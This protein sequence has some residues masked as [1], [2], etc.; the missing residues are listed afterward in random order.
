MTTEPLTDAEVFT[1]AARLIETYGWVQGGNGS[2]GR[3]FCAAGALLA[4]LGMSTDMGYL[5]YPEEA[6]RWSRLAG[7]A[8]NKLAK[9][10]GTFA[11]M[12][13]ITSWNDRLYRKKAEVI[14]FLRELAAE[15]T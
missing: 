5:D 4:A 3:G 10:P 12:G 14:T 9:T 11:S 13:G 6:A 15:A 8:D 2:Q 7:I 1:E